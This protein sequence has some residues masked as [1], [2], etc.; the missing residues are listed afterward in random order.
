M[1]LSE[2]EGEEAIDAEAVPELHQVEIELIQSKFS[3]Y[4]QI[5]KTVKPPRVHHC[6]QCKRCV[7]RMDHH[8]KWI[9]NCV[10]LFNMKHFLLFLI[11]C[12]ILCFYSLGLCLATIFRC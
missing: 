8:C 7:V 9:G 10:G 11:Y 3:K 12:V 6:S 4:C 1:V 5:C 2:T